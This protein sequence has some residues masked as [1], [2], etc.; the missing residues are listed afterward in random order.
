MKIKSMCLGLVFLAFAAIQNNAFAGCSTYTSQLTGSTYSSYTRETDLLATTQVNT[1]GNMHCATT[2]TKWAYDTTQKKYRKIEYCLTCP[3]SYS[4]LVTNTTTV[5]SCTIN[6]DICINC[7]VTS[8][9]P[10]QGS[11]AGVVTTSNCETTTTKYLFSSVGMYYYKITSCNVCENG[12]HKIVKTENN[13][14]S[15]CSTTYD[16]CTWCSAGTYYNQSGDPTTSRCVDCPDG[17]YSTTTESTSC[18]T[19]PSASNPAQYTTS[20]LTTVAS[21]DTGHIKQDN[22][23]S[24]DQCYLARGTYYDAAGTYTTPACFYNNTERA[25]TMDCSIV[26]GVCTTAAGTAGTVYA[27]QGVPL[28]ATGQG[29]ACWCGYGEGSYNGSAKWLYIGTMGQTA[30]SSSGSCATACTESFCTN[31]LSLTGRPELLGCD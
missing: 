2:S 26:Q 3:S 13:G 17:T 5:G 15:R 14:D 30:S 24:A 19:C 18:T 6:Y 31:Q 11:Q 25:S 7:S 21:V 16:D 12:Y 9:T 10:T 23:T 28:G 27:T 29:Q 8:S 20:S 22:D 4:K 1:G